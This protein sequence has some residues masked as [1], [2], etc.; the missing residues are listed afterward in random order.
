MAARALPSGVITITTD[1]GHKG[2]FIGTMKGVILTRFPDAKIVDLTHETLVHWP[3]EAGFWLSR[4]YRYFPPG[5]VHVAVVDPGVGTQREIIAV[6][7]DGHVFLAP[8]NGLLGSI[9][10]APRETVIHQLELDRIAALIPDEPSATFHGRDIFA[11]VA[12]ALAGGEYGVEDLGPQ[13]PDFVPSWVEEPMV[14]GQRVS[15]VVITIDTF[16]NLVTNI[17]QKY[18]A[19]LTGPI[20]RAGG[21]EFSLRRTYGEAAPGQ[22]LALINSF[23]VLEIATAEGSAAK[24]LGIE[25]G[26]PVIVTGATPDEE[27][28]S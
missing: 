2:P 28:S 16:G 26:A 17:D 10:R 1:F 15:G 14:T 9:L 18:L 12:A 13:A 25:R 19:G 3:A 22:H 21:H 24:N 11:P 5:T 6:A 20:V 4:A 7:H 23:G 27:A 8:D